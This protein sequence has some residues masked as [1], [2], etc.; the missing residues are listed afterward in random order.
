MK[1][2]KQKLL[3]ILL[4]AVLG[5]GVTFLMKL[6]EGLA[7]LDG[8]SVPEITGGAASAGAYLKMALKTGFKS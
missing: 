8:N 2:D 1:V 7:G 6:V 3:D 4:A 5:A